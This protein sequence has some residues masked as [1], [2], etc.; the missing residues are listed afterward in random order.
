MGLHLFVDQPGSD[1]PI[2]SKILHI[3]NLVFELVEPN[4]MGFFN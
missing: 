3:L 1:K 4:D 2:Y